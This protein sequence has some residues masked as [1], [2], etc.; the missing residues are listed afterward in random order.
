MKG[1][2]LRDKSESETCIK[3][4][5]TAVQTQFNKKVKFVR[6][7]GAR[8]FAASSIETFYEEQGIE[9]RVTVPY[10]HQTNDTVERAIWTIV[11]IGLS[12]LHHEKLGK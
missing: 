6:H 3:K 2:C 7:D 1:F 8:E 9:Q 10:E 5:A 11:T 12:P 4:H